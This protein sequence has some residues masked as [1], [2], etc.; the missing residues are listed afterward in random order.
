MAAEC[1]CDVYSCAVL[2]DRAQHGVKVELV[3][4]QAFT[5]VSNRVR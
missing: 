3:R 5:C 4:L 1:A 2:F